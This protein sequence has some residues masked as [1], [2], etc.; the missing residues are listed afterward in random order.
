MLAYVFWHRPKVD[1]EIVE[2][3]AAQREFHAAL[4]GTSACLRIAALPFGDGR[5]GYEDWYLVDDWSA[6]GELN[7]TAVDDVRGKGHDRAASLAGAGW[8]AIY[9]LIRG[10]E[11]IPEGVEWLE[12]PR[13]EPSDEFVA[14]LSHESVWRRQL[15]LGPGPEFC[16]AVAAASTRTRL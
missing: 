15:A 8:G 10:A 1:V 2:Y 14:P 13:G 9:E 7:A 3:E 4:P 16:G 6:L 5:R 11:R 12:K